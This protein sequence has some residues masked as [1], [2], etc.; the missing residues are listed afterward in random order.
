MR[1]VEGANFLLPTPALVGLAG[2][3]IPFRRIINE[4]IDI[5]Y[6]HKILLSN[7]FR[8]PE[9]WLQWCPCKAA[10]FSRLGMHKC[11][12]KYERTDYEILLATNSGD[13]VMVDITLTP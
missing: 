2:V 5:V 13:T 1:P 6:I 12:Y 11:H 8:F 9:S 3:G 7:E 10:D 4:K